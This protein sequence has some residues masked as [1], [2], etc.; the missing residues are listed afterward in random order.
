M[1]ILIQF[2]TLFLLSLSLSAQHWT[3]FR[4]ADQTGIV[5]GIEIPT[6]WDL[7][8]NIKWKIPSPGVGWSSPVVWGDQVF[9]TSSLLSK[10]EMERRNAGGGQYRTPEGNEVT[11][12]VVCLDKETGAEMW[13]KTAYSGPT[14]IATHGGSPYSA[15]TPATDGEHVYVH[16]GT[17]GLF[18]FTMEGELAW[19]KDLG[20]YE[21]DS[22]WGTGTSPMVYEGVLFMQIDNEDFSTLLA[23]EGKTGEEIWRVNRE[24]ASNR[25]SPIIWRNKVR[26]ELITQGAITRSYNPQ[27]GELYWQLSVEGGRNS[28][29][30]VGDADRL[31]V[32]NEKRAAGGFMFSIR[33]GAA[34]DISLAE[35]QT[36]NDGIEWKNPNGGIAMS[37]PLLYQG[38]VYAFERRTGMV[39]CYDAAT[40]D[41]HY[42]KKPVKRARE[43][44]SSPWA[45]GGNIYCIDGNGI[46]HVLDGGTEYK[47]IRQNPLDDTIWATP[48]ITPG[49]II[50]KGADSIYAIESGS[51]K[52]TL[53]S[54]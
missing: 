16:F 35:G 5:E 49:S 30:P 50:I 43:F 37:S 3:Q 38:K 27:T 40:G 51:N 14:K 33:A 52:D 2:S 8:S 22:E 21:M 32:A 10:S 19:T 41:V 12:E 20:V 26:T 17:M 4:G 47:E 53:L 54:N 7:E 23:L 44:W 29:T 46:T 1:K 9:I 13:R 28:S 25:S 36:S 48:A 18:A 42:Y 34:G 15:E 6:E 31:I 39:S 45:Y 11:L 24:E